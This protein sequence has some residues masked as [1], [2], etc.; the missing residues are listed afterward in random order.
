VLW[1]RVQVE[2]GARLRRAVIGD[3]VRVP[4]GAVIENAVVVR[5]R[6][7]NEIERGTFVGDNLIVPL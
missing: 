2:S 4:A 5:R 6:V 1:E 3:D 7:V